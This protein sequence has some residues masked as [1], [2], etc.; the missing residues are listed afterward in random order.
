MYAAEQLVP[1]AI[2]NCTIGHTSGAIQ[3]CVFGIESWISEHFRGR[4]EL[5]TIKLFVEISQSWQ[6]NIHIR[7]D[8]AI[9]FILLDP[10]R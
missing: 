6:F 4:S 1:L 5:L 9:N 7:P 10:A 8:Q 2:L 3:Q